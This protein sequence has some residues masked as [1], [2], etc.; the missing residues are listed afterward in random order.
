MEML[1]SKKHGLVKKIILH[2][3]NYIARSCIRDCFLYIK[4]ACLDRYKYLYN[5]KMLTYIKPIFMIT[6]G[7]INRKTYMISVKVKDEL[8]G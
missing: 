1:R 7:I 4:Q 8:M 2:K 6:E 5:K 3:K